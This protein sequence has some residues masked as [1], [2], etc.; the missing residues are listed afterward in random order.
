[1]RIILIGPP[2][3]GKGTQAARLSEKLGIPAIS[4]GDT[5]RANVKNET[6]LGKTA[7]RYMDAGEYVPDE[8]T[9]SMVQDRLNQDDTANGFM[10]D[11]YPRTEA[12][13]HELDRMLKEASQ[14]LDHVVEL[15]ADTD[16]IVARLL[17][18]AQIE[19]RADDTE[20]VIRHR[21]DVYVEQTQPL[22]DIYQER[23]LLRKVDGLGEIDEVTDRVLKALGV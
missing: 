9:N 8:V 19:K 16:E 15:T 17:A 22:T 1:M 20:D 13:V 6:E 21:L 12:Q 11:G 4:T 10:L 7:K 5:F 14:E 2:G 23:G 3:A 18:R